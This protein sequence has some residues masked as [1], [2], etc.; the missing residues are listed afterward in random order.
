VKTATRIEPLEE[1]VRQALKHENLENMRQ[2]LV[3]EH[4]ANVADIIDH[5]PEH[6][7]LAVFKVLPFDYASDVLSE[8]G[9]EA[10]REIIQQLQP[11]EASALLNRLSSDD[12]AEILGEDIPEQQQ[13]LLAVMKPEM[14]ERV[15]QMLAFPP[16]SAGRL[17]VQQ[18]VAVRPEMRTADVL[19]LLQTIN[20]DIETITDLYMLDSAK[21]LLG[22]IGL[23]QVLQS[24]AER[25]LSEYAYMHQ[26]AVAPET[27]QEDVARL[28]SQ[29]DLFALPVVADDRRMLGIITVDDV[30]DVLVEESTEDV[31]RLGAVQGG[32]TDETYFSTPIVR[33]V[34]RRVGWLLLLF[35]A[36]TI[37]INVLSWFES[38]L[39]QVV[40]LSFFIPLL[41]GTGGNTGAQTVSTMVRGIAL[42]EVHAGDLFR[43]ILREVGSGLL[44]GTVL[45]VFAFILALLLGNT[46]QLAIVVACSIIA[47][48]TWA[49]TI[50]AV[51]PMLAR[52]FNLDPALVSAP[53]IS[54]L[55]DATGLAIYLSIAKV[56]LGL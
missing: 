35:V 47:I 20:P 37:T 29:H 43:V 11:V 12:L 42:N 41:I 22:V 16:R 48:C 39:S 50:G 38:I 19:E 15:R 17:M 45:S 44:L 25:P 55:V 21:R 10:T 4:P 9:V 1:Q 56:V 5:L 8:T 26:I 24:P 49:N 46:L 23:R 36:G 6:E 52:R 34:R 32:A 30:I 54:T 51:V 53:L 13:K 27:D 14:A 28:V 3:A 18:F 33:A 40:T 2:T 7:R 31:L